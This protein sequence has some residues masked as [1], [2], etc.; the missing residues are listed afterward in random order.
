MSFELS[1]NEFMAIGCLIIVFILYKMI[2]R[3]QDD[4]NSDEYK[5]GYSDGYYNNDVV[6]YQEL[7]IILEKSLDT[8]DDEVRYI[9]G[10]IRGYEECVINK[11]KIKIK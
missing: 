2:E 6:K 3:N 8:H 1:G 7:Q 5:K 10:Y 4:I 11:N 9:R